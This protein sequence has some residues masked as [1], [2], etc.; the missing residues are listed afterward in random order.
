M[1]FRSKLYGGAVREDSDGLIVT[2]GSDKISFLTPAAF[3]RRFP[4]IAIPEDLAEG[5]FAG[6]TL[7]VRALDKVAAIIA[8]AGLSAVRTAAGS[9]VVAPSQAANTLLEFKQA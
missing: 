8:A 9:L 3:T 1:L 6:A 4:T 7:R 2:L 5:W